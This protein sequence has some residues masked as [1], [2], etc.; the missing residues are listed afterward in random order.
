VNKVYLRDPHQGWYH[1]GLPGIAENII[2]LAG[3]L[4]K[5]FSEHGIT[6]PVMVG[7]SMGGFA[8]L[9]FG[10]LLKVPTIHSFSPQTFI[11]RFSRWRHKDERWQEQ[12]ETVLRSKQKKYLDLRKVLKKEKNDNCQYTIYYSPHDRL[13]E[14][15]AS[16]MAGIKNVVLKPC[17][18]GGHGVIKILRD[19]GT[20]K[21]LILES[22]DR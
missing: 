14:I 11:N 19:N 3:F 10:A 12:V 16:R 1:F 5:K 21:K 8:A 13:D 6:N 7:N 15:H 20:L 9:L 2:E 17:G 4:E 18:E 22:F